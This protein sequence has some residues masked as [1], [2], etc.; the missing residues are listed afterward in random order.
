MYTQKHPVAK[1]SN[2]SVLQSAN[3][4]QDATLM[5][6]HSGFLRMK[7]IRMLGSEEEKRSRMNEC[8]KKEEGVNTGEILVKK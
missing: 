2:Y 4:P 1:A 7:G 5:H 8:R 6:L 3:L